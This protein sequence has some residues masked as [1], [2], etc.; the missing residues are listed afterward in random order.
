MYIKLVDI[1]K[2]HSKNR[3]SF[4]RSIGRGSAIPYI[5]DLSHAAMDIRQSPFFQGPAAELTTT[6]C[7]VTRR[8]HSQSGTTSRP[9][10]SLDLN[11]GDSGARSS[12]GGPWRPPASRR[13]QG[14]INLIFSVFDFRRGI[15]RRWILQRDSSIFHVRSAVPSCLKWI[16]VKLLFSFSPLLPFCS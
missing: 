10:I 5:K 13:R 6:S 9:F 3:S 12:S 4:W 2:H 11:R 14:E 15:T 16:S 7:T 1:W 8:S